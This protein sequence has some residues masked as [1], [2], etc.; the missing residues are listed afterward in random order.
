MYEEISKTILW[1]LTVLIA[2]GLVEK[3]AKKING[4]LIELRQTLLI[5]KKFKWQQV[6]NEYQKK[7]NGRRALNESR[8]SRIP[9]G[10]DG[11]I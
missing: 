3:I 10:R 4:I 5:S 9:V 2:V 11:S 1:L 6:K 7:K 8:T